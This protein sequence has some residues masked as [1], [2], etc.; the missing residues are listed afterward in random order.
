[1]FIALTFLTFIIGYALGA[2][3]GLP[4]NKKNISDRINY[5]SLLKEDDEIRI[6]ERGAY[7][8]DTKKWYIVVANDPT[9]K[10]L[11]LVRKFGSDSNAAGYTYG[12]DC[13]NEVV[14][15]NLAVVRGRIPKQPKK[16]VEPIKKEK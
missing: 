1:M 11:Q 4:F 16:K 2:T 3:L 8:K 6:F 15:D 14:G 12:E 7:F 13:L 10:I 5:L 9:L